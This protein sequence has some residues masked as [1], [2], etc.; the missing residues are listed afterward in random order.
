[1][2]PAARILFLGAILGA[3]TG[4]GDIVTVAEFLVQD[5][6]IRLEEDGS[7]S[8][9]LAAEVTGTDAIPTYE[10]V[11]QPTLGQLVGAGT[12]FEYVPDE[13]A[14]GQ[15]Q[16]TWRA[17][18]SDTEQSDLATVTV[19]IDPVNDAPRGQGSQLVVDEDTPGSGPLPAS[20]VEGD[21]LTYSLVQAPEFGRVDIGTDGTFTYTPDR[22]YV[23]T[24][25]FLWAATDD[26]N[27]STGPVRVDINV[28]PEN[29][30]P[31]V[32][33]NGFVGTEDEVLAGTLFANDPD[34]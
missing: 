14:N 18:V 20:D 25:T 8:V 19:F 26:S 24:D 2:T 22:N 34:G 21:A 17:F 4:D 13:N 15:D 6:S 9:V 7:A 5:G 23:G 11:D 3:C 30:A 10:I 32:S 29:D 28:A 31:I 16:F 12:V 33:D 27:A 1:M